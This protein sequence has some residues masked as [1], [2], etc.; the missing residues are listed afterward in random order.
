MG[1]TTTTTTTRTCLQKAVPTYRNAPLTNTERNAT[2][3]LGINHKTI[4]SL[5]RMPTGRLLGLFLRL[6][7]SLATITGSVSI[8]TDPITLLLPPPP[9]SPWVT[10][11]SVALGSAAFLATTTGENLLVARDVEAEGTVARRCAV[12]TRGVL[13]LLGLQTVFCVVLVTEMMGSGK[14]RNEYCR[15][16]LKDQFDKSREINKCREH[17]QGTVN[18]LIKAQQITLRSEFPSKRLIL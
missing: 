14:L 13:V 9:P 6:L 12:V 16:S 5:C 4:H 7:F 11:V 10:A 3:S 17:H 2:K 18:Q 1:T 15:F 8:T